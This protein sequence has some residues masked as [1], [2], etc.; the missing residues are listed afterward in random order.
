MEAQDDDLRGLASYDIAGDF[1]HCVFSQCW[2]AQ[3][4]N[5]F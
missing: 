2:L 3:I 4:E 5:L 1:I